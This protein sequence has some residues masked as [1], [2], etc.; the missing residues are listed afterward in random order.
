MCYNNKVMGKDKKVKNKKMSI[1]EIILR[2]FLGFLIPFV[3]INGLI[4]Y[5]YIQSPNIKVISPDSDEF[6]KNK[7]KFTVDCKLPIKDVEV[8][9]QDNVVA[10]TR[11][12][13][14][15]IV[16]VNTNGSYQIT[17]TAINNATAKCYGGV[18]TI[19]SVAPTI[20]LD[21]AIITGNTLIISIHDDQSQINYDKLYATL[22]DGTKVEPKQVDKTIGSVQ[23]QIDKGNKITVHLEDEHEN[24]SET[25]FTIS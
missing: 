3:I 4:F 22:E 7:I 19:D 15:Y 10:Y 16:E 6:E 9:F 23:F 21:T 11:L 1:A 14:L 24:S 13:D 18:E 20:D 8:T 25:P 2:F 12:K 5:I 17:A